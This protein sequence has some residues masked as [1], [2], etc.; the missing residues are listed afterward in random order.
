MPRLED[1]RIRNALK[2]RLLPYYS[3][4]YRCSCEKW[5]RFFLIDFREE[6]VTDFIRQATTQGHARCMMPETPMQIRDAVLTACPEPV[7]EESDE[8]PLQTRQ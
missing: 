8:L 3:F 7:N 4:E 2:L 1:G 5:L 6:R